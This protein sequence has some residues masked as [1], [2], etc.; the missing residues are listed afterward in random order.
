MAEHREF[1]DIRGAGTENGPALE[2]DEY[3]QS[4]EALQAEIATDKNIVWERVADGMLSDEYLK[5]LCKEYEEGLAAFGWAGER[6][7]AS[8]N[9]AR[10]M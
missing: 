5:R 10:M 8:T 3:M 4:L 2:V 9:Y 1:K 6:F 7:A